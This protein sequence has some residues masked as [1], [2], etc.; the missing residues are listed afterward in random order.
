MSMHDMLKIR[1]KEKYA[2]NNKSKK[3]KMFLNMV[4]N[5]FLRDVGVIACTSKVIVSIK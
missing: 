2:K 1:K 5:V 4:V 3:I